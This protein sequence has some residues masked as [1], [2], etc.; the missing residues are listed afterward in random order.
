MMRESG[1]GGI[2]S[3]AMGSA[4][5]MGQLGM[6]NNNRQ[7]YFPNKQ[8][9]HGGHR[10]HHQWSEGW[11]GQLPSHGGG[12]TRRQPYQQQ[13]LQPHH[14]FHHASPKCGIGG[15]FDCGSNAT[16]WYQ[17]ESPPPPNSPMGSV[18]QCKRCGRLGHMA[19]IGT[20]HSGLKVLAIA[21]VSMA[22]ATTTASPTSTTH[23]LMLRSLVIQVALAGGAAEICHAPGSNNSSSP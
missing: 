18:Y 15:P 19:Q 21:V 6:D 10:R 9:Q 5:H 16:G 8:Q 11:N 23:T 1:T 14:S 20:T 3:R 17:E 12:Q 13:L 2:A 7:F 22:T 4:V